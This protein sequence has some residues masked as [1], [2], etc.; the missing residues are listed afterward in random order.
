MLNNSTTFLGFDLG[1]ADSHLAILDPDRDLI[2]RT[3]LSRFGNSS[4][5]YG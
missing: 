5:C 2:E 3:R 4:R 1:D